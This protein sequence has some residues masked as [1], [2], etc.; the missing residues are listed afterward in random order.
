MIIG[1]GTD[2]CEIA[3]IKPG[4]G[5]ADKILSAK[6]QVIFANKKN[7][8]AY[9]AK[10]FAAKEAVAKAFG[11]GIGS[12]LAFCDISVLNNEHGAPYIELSETA[13]AKLPEFS[14]IHISISDEKQYALAYVVVEKI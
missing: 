7:K 13:T 12:K 9:L 8:Q 6:E 5:F 10:R 2:I 4:Q 14:N 1:I 3:R 11:F